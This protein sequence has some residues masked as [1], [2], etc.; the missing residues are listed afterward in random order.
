MKYKA[1]FLDVD[2]TLV[3]YDYGALPSEKVAKAVQKAQEKISVCLVTGRGFGFVEHVLQKLDISTGLA[4]VNT[5]AVVIDIATKRVIH[6]QPIELNDAKEIVSVLQEENIDFYIKQ[7]LHGLDHTKGFFK[8]GQELTK[9]YMFFTD[10]VYS[11][12]KIEQVFKRLSHLTEIT[13]HMSVHRDPTK[14]GIN[15]GHIKATK[16]HGVH[17]LL[18]HLKVSKDEVIGVGDS[19]NDFPLLMASG[20]KVAMGNAVDELKEIADYIA[21]SVHDD[22]VAD[23]IEKYITLPNQE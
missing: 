4:V 22:G 11:Q 17:I 19:Y 10:D 5:G 1:L 2:G 8:K 7:D 3:P 14:F 9:A 21:P 15:I 13:T 6:E 23:V 16:L 18:E 20:L 12:E